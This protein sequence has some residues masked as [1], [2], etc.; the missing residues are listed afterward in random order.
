VRVVEVCR[1]TRSENGGMIAVAELQKR[2]AKGRTGL[3]GAGMDVTEDDVLRARDS[4]EPLGG[5][6]QVMT[7]G[8]SKFIR[9]VPKELNQDQSTVLEVIQVLGHVTVSMLRANLGWDRARALAVIDDLVAD[10]LVWV[11]T[12]GEE[13]EFWSPAGMHEG[14]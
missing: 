5:M 1:E 8:G 2:I 9:S 3:V 7:L 4:L 14:G 11:D 6:F 12:Q 10:S 13:T